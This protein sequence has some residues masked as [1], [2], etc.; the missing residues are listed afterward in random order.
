MKVAAA[1]LDH[2]HLS[3]C[4]TVGRGAVIQR[5]H[6]VRDALQLHVRT[7]R[8]SIVQQQHGAVAPAKELLERQYL[9]AIAQGALRQQAKLRQRV[10]HHAYRL[11]SLDRL[12][13]A[14]SRF[15]QL[16][17][18]RVIHRELVTA[19]EIA[20][21]RDQLDDLYAVQ[22]PAVRF[23]AGQQLLSRFGQRDIQAGFAGPGSGEQILK[24]ERRLACARIAVDQIEPLADQAAVEH[25][26]QARHARRSSFEAYFRHSRPSELQRCRCKR[27]WLTLLGPR[28]VATQL[29]SWPR[30]LEYHS[31]RPVTPTEA[32]I[33]GRADWFRRSGD[34]GDKKMAGLATKS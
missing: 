12:Q 10:E 3:Q 17:F 5:D 25:L 6:A 29:S 4:L 14:T 33:Q 7:F 21:F 22:R 2:L 23:R 1:E 9:P 8:S 31:R 11:G 16:H 26:V 32:R 30:S 19:G 24:R 15:G 18:G 20:V 13:H 28:I 34:G 27:F